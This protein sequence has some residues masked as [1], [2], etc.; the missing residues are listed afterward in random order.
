M[1]TLRQAAEQ[2]L[3]ALKLIDNAMPFPVAKL[4]IKHLKEVLEDESAQQ[5]PVAWLWELTG[6][7]TTDPD[8]ADGMWLPLYTSPPASKPWVGLTDEEIEALAK[9]ADKNA[10]PWHL[11]FARAIEAKLEEKNQ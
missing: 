6:E 9:W 10:A 2:A 5:E 7:V 3:E 8:R 1:T 11:E 4:T